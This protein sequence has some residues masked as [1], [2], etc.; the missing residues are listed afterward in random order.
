MSKVKTT[1]IAAGEP[2]SDDTT[3]AAPAAPPPGEPSAPPLKPL[4][5]IKPLTT[6]LA[7]APDPLR[8]GLETPAATP[9]PVETNP[10]VRLVK[11]KADSQRVGSLSAMEVPGGCLVKSSF[12]WPGYMGESICFVPCVN[13]V[14]G[15]LA[16]TKCCGKEQA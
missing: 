3:T 15:K 11:W 4:P 2:M 1:A 5:E 13:I 10:F 16:P 8:P 12:A 9:A 7:P 6:P 14:D